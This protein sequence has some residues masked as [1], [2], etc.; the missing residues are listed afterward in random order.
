MS[1]FRSPPPYLQQILYYQASIDGSKFLSFSK[2]VPVWNDLS[3]MYYEFANF[4]TIKRIRN[5]MLLEALLAII[6]MKTSER[7]PNS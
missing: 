3:M 2:T 7:S 6:I 5:L 4:K 1:F